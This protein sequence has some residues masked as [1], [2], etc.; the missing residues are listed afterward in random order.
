MVD[1]LLQGVGACRQGFDAP[2]QPVSYC[3]LGKSCS[4]RLKGE[5]ALPCLDYLPAADA[6][7]KHH[8][9]CRLPV[10][11]GADDHAHAVGVASSEAL[12]T[13]ISKGGEPNV[14]PPERIDREMPAVMLVGR[15]PGVPHRRPAAH[16]EKLDGP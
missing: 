7:G 1:Y 9:P 13:R 15:A 14:A 4:K 2:P 8:R 12:K 16:G 5:A 3:L 11:L 10:I 6:S